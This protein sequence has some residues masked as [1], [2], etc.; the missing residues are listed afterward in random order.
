[1][2]ET[3]V[4]LVQAGRIN[5]VSFGHLFRCI[6]ISKK[7]KNINPYF[8]INKNPQ[9]ENILRSKKISFETIK[10]F[11]KKEILEKIKNIDTKKIVIDMYDIV[12]NNFIKSL[13]KLNYKT[14]LIDD[15]PKK[16]ISADII[17]NYSI[18][19]DYKK[20]Y[21][22]YKKIFFGPKYLIPFSKKKETGKKK[23]ILVFFGGSDINNYSEKVINILLKLKINAKIKLI[24]G[25]GYLKSKY[26]KLK[27]KS[28]K[29]FEVVYNVKNLEKEISKHNLIIIS[30]GY[31]MYK[32]MFMNKLCLVVPTS[33]HEIKIAKHIKKNN[34]GLV[35][36]QKLKDFNK[37]LS[38]ALNNNILKNTLK[39]NMSKLFS[40]NLFKEFIKNL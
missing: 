9:S 12:D 33:S 24:L 31:S 8:L 30:A 29:E 35:C 36:D 11:K 14:I 4:F 18:I 15:V 3:V 10:N 22:D 17:Y 7:I 23:N 20:K 28:K 38:Q 40:K 6:Q 39:K 26:Y 25:P 21:F 19:K 34:L 2:I 5:K 27:K 32:A 16:K 13:K 1:M 37:F